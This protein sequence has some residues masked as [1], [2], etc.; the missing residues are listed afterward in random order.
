M[1]LTLTSILAGPVL[2]RSEAGRVCIWIAT[3]TDVTI[4]GE[5]FGADTALSGTY[6]Q[7][8][9]GETSSLRFGKAFFVTLVEI[10]P[11]AR[12]GLPETE[13]FP[14]GRLLAYDLVIRARDK[15][16][17]AGQRLPA[18]FS[19]IDDPKK[20][21]AYPK[22]PLPT[23]YL[24]AGTTTN[25]LHG[26][27]RK[28]RGEEG[29]ALILADQV[30]AKNLGI[31]VEDGSVAQIDK[32]PSALF[33][34]GDQ[35]YADDVAEPLVEPLLD[36]AKRLIGIDERLPRAG[37]DP[38]RRSSGRCGYWGNLVR[39]AFSMVPPPP[40]RGWDPP[41]LNAPMRNHLVS[42]ADFA[43]M[44]LLSLGPSQWPKQW[45][46]ESRCKYKDKDWRGDVFNLDRA[47]DAL[48]AVRRA[49]ANIP[50]YMIFDDH[51]V[52]DDWNLTEAWRARVAKDPLAR[53]VVANALAAYWLFQAWGDDPD[54]FKGLADEIVKSLTDEDRNG[55]AFEKTLL[56]HGSWAFLAPTEPPV[57]LIDSRTQRSFDPNPGDPPGASTKPPH[58]LGAEEA[59]N[60]TALAKKALATSPR[61]ML[62]VVTATPVFGV[63][64]FEGFQRYL[65]RTP[66]GAE[67][68]DFEAWSA[69][70]AGYVAFL[71][72]MSAAEPQS[73]IILSGD[74]HY[75]FA[76][77]FA[78]KMRSGRA[79]LPGLQFTSS[80]LKN[81]IVGSKR[82]KL[83]FAA[84]MNFPYQQLDIWRKPVHAGAASGVDDATLK[85]L[86]QSPVIVNA[87]FTRRVD[88][89][90]DPDL[91]LRLMLLKNRGG[92]DPMIR[93]DCGV[94]QLLVD[95]EAV[96]AIF[97]AADRV[98]SSKDAPLVVTLDLAAPPPSPP[99]ASSPVPF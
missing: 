57:L 69:N 94:G 31:S 84:W 10:K 50:T 30:I 39:S 98:G 52:T 6:T 79:W 80:A 27:C 2:R 59:R 86:R 11:I 29:D 87:G 18:F 15:P 5:I 82:D 13:T 22:L 20:G 99:V 97:H 81:A 73:V 26:S 77:Q 62:I 34:T 47:K 14:K 70:P 32:R 67:E 23:F 83:G 85:L 92:R 17:A 38:L 95:G 33:L 48:P 42:F 49:L 24:S 19:P 43:G 16:Y 90:E 71:D 65:S 88:I 64:E 89:V 7:I 40:R 78:L 21:I 58:L 46:G 4:T 75:S 41:E 66:K 45:P 96:Q 12:K 55:G 76:T 56:E 3:D 72:A 91:Q 36:I 37:L 25:F 9:K 74:V 93:F 51:E 54:S 61:G 63:A 28:L 44:Y 68:Y 1:A 53:R 8:G 60:V 35:I